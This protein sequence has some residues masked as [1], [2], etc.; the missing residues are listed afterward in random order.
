M[1]DVVVLDYDP[2]WPDHFE[3]LRAIVWPAVA[4]I[5]TAIEHLGSTSVPGLS[6]KPVI[7][8]DVVVP[9]SRVE[10][11]I[12]RL[13]DLGD[14]H[15]GNLGIEGREAFRAPAGSVPHHLY[16]CPAD[17]PAL[18]NHIAVRDH[19]RATPTAAGRTPSPRPT[20]QIRRLDTA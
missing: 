11:A 13:A 4:G 6:A 16:L 20:S 14:R 10:E 12:S 1:A 9:A 17:S 18:A 2:R 15:R 3:Q 5:A 19:L 8:M 7:D